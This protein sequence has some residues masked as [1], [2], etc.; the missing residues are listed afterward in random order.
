[1]NWKER[2][3]SASAEWFTITHQCFSCFCH[4]WATSVTVFPTWFS[5]DLVHTWVLTQHSS[6]AMC[7]ILIICLLS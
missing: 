2:Q 6:V 7:V 5:V 1:M 3:D 4:H